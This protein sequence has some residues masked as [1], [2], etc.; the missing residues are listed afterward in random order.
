VGAGVP[1]R[2]LSRCLLAA[3]G[4]FGSGKIGAR[5]KGNIV[6]IQ[7]RLLQKFDGRF[8]TRHSVLTPDG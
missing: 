8:R 4:A 6:K 7:N 1:A 3:A 2:L 5:L